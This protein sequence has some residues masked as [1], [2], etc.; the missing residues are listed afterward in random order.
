MI[1]SHGFQS[2]KTYA[3]TDT[4]D[5]KCALERVRLT[6]CPKFLYSIAFSFGS[7]LMTRFLGETPDQSLVNA[8]VGISTPFDYLKCANNLLSFWNKRV[9]NAYLTKDIREIV[10]RNVDIIRK[11]APN[12]DVDGALAATTVQQFDA[13]VTCRQYGFETPEDYYLEATVSSFLPRIRIPVLYINAA[14]D[15]FCPVDAIPKDVIRNQCPP[16]SRIAFLLLDCGSHIS[17]LQQDDTSI[18]DQV[19]LEF[20][21]SIRLENAL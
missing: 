8:Y 21:H 5:L 15:P 2:G 17:F 1:C 7:V 20:I 4:T 9:Y 18:A 14:D 6:K 16:S 10:Y 11:D 19:G 13:A 12:V 3:A